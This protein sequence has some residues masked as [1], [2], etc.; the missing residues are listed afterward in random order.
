MSR[1]GSE[2]RRQCTENLCKGS[3]MSRFA[4]AL[5]GCAR[6]NHGIA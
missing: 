2:T 3:A 4:A 1:N 5:S 6:H